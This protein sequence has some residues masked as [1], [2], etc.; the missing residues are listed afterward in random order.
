MNDYLKET[1]LM[2]F[3]H[4]SIKGLIQKKGWMNIS[5]KDK[6]LNIYNFVRDEIAFGFNADYEVRASK[7]IEDGYGH[8]NTKGILFMALLRAVGIPCR[9][10]GFTIDKNLQKGVLTGFWHYIAPKEIVHSWVEV[11][12][13]DRWMKLEGFILDMKYLASLQKKYKNRN[14]NFCGFG[15]ATNDFQNPNV[16]WKGGD[17]YIQKEGIVKDFGIYDDPDSFFKEHA[18][19]I[20]GIKKL[21]Y[22]HVVRTMM[23]RNI[24]RIR[25]ERQ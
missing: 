2:D 20:F 15:V 21:L 5:E 6:I 18:Q 23:N 3:H 7:V 13:Q 9:M 17:T 10:H 4:S 25:K 19:Q 22:R 14:G 1:A 16:D 24:E 11:L 12:F 8:C